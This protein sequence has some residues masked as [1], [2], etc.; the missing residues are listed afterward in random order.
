MGMHPAWIEIDLLQLQRNISIVRNWIGKDTLFCL[1]VKANA[2][3]HGLC[4]IGKYAEKQGVDY[5][6]VA[7]LEEGISL[8]NAGVHIP[9]LIFGAI[10]EDQIGE[11][12]NYN[13]EFTISSRW[14][15]ELVSRICRTKKAPIHI[16]ID[17]GHRRTGVRASN[18]RALFLYLQSLDCFNIIGIYSHLATADQPNNSFAHKQIE[19]FISLIEDPIFKEK[20]LISHL[21]N[22]GGTLH[23]PASHLDMVRPGLLT[24]G[25]NSAHL[26][27]QPC[28][29]LKA[30]VAYFK[31]V[32]EGEG[33]SYGHTFT[34][35]STTRI[36]TL[37]IGYG[38][39]YLRRL[40]NRGSVLIRGKRFPIVGMICM[41]QLMVDIGNNE[42]FVGEEAVLIGKQ[43]DEEISVEEIS[44]L[45]DTLPY[46]ILCLLNSRL[47][48]IYLS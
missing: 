2:Y 20:K 30:K 32:E 18:G 12:I 31:V 13:F 14:K 6:A 34:T 4:E 43:G 22:S 28:F 40:S 47:P 16:E 45:C 33:I 11:L 39:G 44:L 24:F 3:G 15:G 41:D 35:R 10:H 38:D 36:V 8:R 46:E 25:Y 9:I 23:Y 27:V 1:P 26:P 19:T 21:A 17:T 48:R 42:V 7:H 29:S 5:L 37:P